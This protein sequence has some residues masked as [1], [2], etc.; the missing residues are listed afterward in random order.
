MSRLVADEETK[1]GKGVIYAIV[2][3]P[4]GRRYVGATTT[5][6]SLRMRAHLNPLNK[7]VHSVKSLQEDWSRDGADAFYVDVI[8]RE[9]DSELLHNVESEW[10]ERYRAESGVY[11]RTKEAPPF[12]FGQS[13][14]TRTVR[15]QATN[16]GDE[17]DRQ[18][19]A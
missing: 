7:G 13:V 11:N 18:Q 1:R 3:E 16:V 2:H 14:F 6:L 15:A 5:R 12:R 9:V 10:I 4:S 17:Q 19:S 8:A